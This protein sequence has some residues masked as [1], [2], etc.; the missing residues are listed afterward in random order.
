MQICGLVY[1]QWENW[2]CEYLFVMKDGLQKCDIWE[3]LSHI[4][5]ICMAKL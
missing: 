4:S 2:I 1:T 5:Y 3:R